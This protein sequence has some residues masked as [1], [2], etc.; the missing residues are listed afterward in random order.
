MTEPVALR[1]PLGVARALVFSSS[2]AVLVL[3]ILAGRLMAP[4]V[5][6]SLETFTGII[7]VVLAG[8]AVGTSVGGRLADRLDP[9]ALLGPAYVLGGALSWW[10][11]W[12]VLREQVNLP[13]T[14]MSVQV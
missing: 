8:I 13:G 4:Y 7:G 3:E 9:A 1:M 10:S 6:V 5:G 2:A 12:V 14:V 11:L